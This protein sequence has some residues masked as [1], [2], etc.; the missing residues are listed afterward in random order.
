MA[1]VSI[2]NETLTAIGAAI[3]MKNNSSISYRPKDMPRAIKSIVIEDRDPAF[4][5][6]FLERTITSYTNSRITKT[7]HYAF[8]GC[9][10]LTTVSMP[11]L[12]E[13]GGCAFEGCKNL[14]T[15][16][17]PKVQIIGGSAFWECY[18]LT[19]ITLPMANTIGQQSF[20]KCSS[21]TTVDIG[22]SAVDIIEFGHNAFQVFEYCSALTTLILRSNRVC[23]TLNSALA[24][25]MTNLTIYVPANL[26]AGYQSKYTS[27]NFATIES[28]EG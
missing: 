1:Y 10:N 7:K 14:T 11:N 12:I 13:L 16:N 3:R 17:L 2:N 26:L 6:A 9:V 24:S 28:L 22:S 4:E 27:Y 25:N 5:K 20:C 8:N 23:S 19:S 18:N 21:L 15:V